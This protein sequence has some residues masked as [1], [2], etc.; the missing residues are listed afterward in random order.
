[1]CQ[2]IR[3]SNINYDNILYIVAKDNN[4]IEL[5]SLFK[6]NSLLANLQP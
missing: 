3:D 6:H 4:I 2:V 5:Q 1:M